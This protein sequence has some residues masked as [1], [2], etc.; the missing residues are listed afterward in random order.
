[1]EDYQDL[2]ELK[3][4]TFTKPLELNVSNESRK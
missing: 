1:M 2:F 3:T 4:E